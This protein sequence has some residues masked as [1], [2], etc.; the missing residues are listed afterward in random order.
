MSDCYLPSRLNATNSCRG[1]TP[2][3]RRQAAASLRRRWFGPVQLLTPPSAP[4]AIGAAAAAAALLSLAVIT[5]EIPDR[6]RA[7]GVLSPVD[8]LLKVRA[9]RAGRIEQLAVRNGDTVGRHQVLMRISGSQHA[10]GR[11]PELAARIASLQRELGL[12][13]EELQREIDA[14]DERTIFNSKR[15][16]VTKQR[17]AVAQ[18]ELRTR[19]QHAVLSDARAQRFH[20]L[21]DSRAVAEHLADEFAAT[22]LQAAATRELA[23]QRVLGLQDELLAIEQQLAHDRTLPAILHHRA[24]IKR[25]AIERQIAAGELLSAVE[26]T[27]PDAGVVSGVAVRVGEEVAVGSVLM[28]LH[29]PASRLEARLFLSPDN[30][31]MISTGQRVELQLK[32]YPHQ[33]YG[34]RSAIVR[35][36]SA[37]TIAADEIDAG[38]V[39]SGPVFEVRAE[40]QDSAVM[41]SGRTWSLPPGTSFT[42]DLVRRRW[43]LFRWLWRSVSG[44]MSYS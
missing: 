28:T 27:A 26:I 7:V 15:L 9:S 2:L 36:V 11:A 40:L 3:F 30:A 6:V 21:A 18:T 5:I 20:R 34:T 39:F 17:I 31:G 43:P 37:T 4:A 25:E 24:A 44:D 23:H 38:L 8:G 29:D 22:A 32:A 42:A 10:P 13:D 19:E 16:D 33:L 1:E 14:V 12:L 35:S 41:V